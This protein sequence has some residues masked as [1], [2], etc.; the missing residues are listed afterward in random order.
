MADPWGHF[1]TD[2]R[3]RR[4]SWER[5]GPLAETSTVRPRAT[6][7]NAGTV[8]EDVQTS[9]QLGAEHTA[10]ELIFCPGSFLHLHYGT[11]Q[12]RSIAKGIAGSSGTQLQGS[13][14]STSG[15]SPGTGMAPPH[16]VPILRELYGSGLHSPESK[17]R[18]LG[19]SWPSLPH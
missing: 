1:C 5:G 16:M 13:G 2:D 18:W 3:G 15:R 9:G 14:I 19:A 10:G 7:P 12:R 6:L 4:Q 11:S 8:T 17:S